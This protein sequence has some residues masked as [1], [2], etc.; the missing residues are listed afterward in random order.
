MHCEQIVD[1]E[2]IEIRHDY[3]KEEDVAEN[4]VSGGNS[5]AARKLSHA[6]KCTVQQ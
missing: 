6:E 4:G 2:L 1:Q 5:I 3:N